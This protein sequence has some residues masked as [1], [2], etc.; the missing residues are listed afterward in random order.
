MTSIIFCVEQHQYKRKGLVCMLSRWLMRLLSKGCAPYSFFWPC[1]WR[2]CWHV[3]DDY[4]MQ[5]VVAADLPFPL[6]SISAFSQKRAALRLLQKPDPY[7][8]RK[9]YF[10]PVP[11]HCCACGCK[12]SWMLI[13]WS[14]ACCSL[15]IVV[16]LSILMWHSSWNGE[17]IEARLSQESESP[18]IRH[19]QSHTWQLADGFF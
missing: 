13:R 6:G 12:L 18:Y 19:T 7:T 8:V 17:V 1:S 9:P 14:T 4:V 11:L 10:C 5:A 16:R 15:E 3:H 2:K